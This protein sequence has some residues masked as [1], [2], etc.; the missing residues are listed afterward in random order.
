MTALSIQPP[1]PIF[2]DTDGSPLENGY[3]WLGTANQDPQANPITAYWDAALT[4]T[5][6]Q[7][8]RTSGGYP[9]RSG[10]PARLYVAS[11]YSIRVQ[12]KNGSQVYS[13]PDGASDR[14]SA[15]QIS[16][17]QAGSGAVVRT[18]QSKMRDVV[19]VK[20]FGAVGDGVADDTV[21]IQAAITYAVASRQ[22]LPGMVVG[23]SAPEIHFTEGAKY[24]VTGN[25]SVGAGIKL[26]GNKSIITSGTYPYPQVNP[27]FINVAP[28]CIID[29][30]VTFG[31]TDIIKI[32]TANL[33]AAVIEVKNC[34][35]QEWSG[36]AIYVDNNSASTLLKIHDNK[37]YARAASAWIVKNECDVCLF[38]DNWVE[39]PCDTFFWNTKQLY[40]RGMLGVPTASTPGSRWIYNEGTQLTC[41]DSRFGGEPGARTIV[42]QITGPGGINATKLVV[43]NCEVWSTGFPLVRF[44]DIPDVFAFTR[45][46]GFNGSYPFQFNAI[47]SATRNALGSRNTWTVGENEQVEIGG[48]RSSGD[49][50]TANNKAAMI[51]NVRA[52]LGTE[53]FTAS[54]VVRN[55]LY[56]EIGFGNTGSITT[57]MSSSTTVDVF[58]ATVQTINGI[59]GTAQFNTNWTTLL[60]GLPAGSY[61]MLVNIAVNT[62]ASVLLTLNAGNNVRTENLTIGKYTL[63]VPFYFDGTNATVCG[64]AVKNICLGT[65]IAHGGLRVIAGTVDGYK[66]WNTECLGTAAPVS[67]Y[68]R[69][70]DRVINSAPTVGQPKAWVCTVA[71]T[72]GTW[73]SEGNL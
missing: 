24:L 3:I 4:I 45:N 27:L 6:A 57:G 56:T 50:V 39:G 32:A 19:S 36:Y 1:F 43:E 2:T 62:G 60:A 66:K 44:S 65:Q 38:D 67:G 41:R 42:D 58:G 10:T 69:L 31:F 46:Y 59:N 23:F 15:A 33:D 22:Q 18:A 13:A 37:F 64:Y 35:I 28:D 48:L 34:E 61:T 29:G 16:F 73:V 9:A 8:I 63:A 72:P 5:A 20:D 30:F 12:N 14:F 70:G 25:I 51:E 55:I 68:W 11:D 52:A 47:P 53:T 26:F 17:L 21:A 7:P 49:D 54:N 40:I 71:G